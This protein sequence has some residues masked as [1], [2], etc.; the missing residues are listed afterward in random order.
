MIEAKHNNLARFIFNA[1]EYKLLKKS[2]NRFILL[3]DELQIS[4]NKSVIFLPNHFSWWDGFFIDFLVR[5]AEVNK[6]FHIIMLEEQLKKYWFFRFLGATGFNP[7]NPKSI[8]KLSNYLSKLLNSP[9]NSV[10][11]YPQGEIQYYDQDLRVKDGLAYLLK[12]VNSQVDVFYPFFK[13]LYFDQK[14]P[15][16]FCKVYYGLQIE[17]IN[18]NYQLFIEDFKKKYND[19]RKSNININKK[20]NLFISEHD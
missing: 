10:V 6:K 20:R 13:I 3:N 18:N 9:N 4:D 1:Y 8:V 12:H 19:F 2:F 17:T 16:L 5:N 11:F 14:L 15:D 7:S